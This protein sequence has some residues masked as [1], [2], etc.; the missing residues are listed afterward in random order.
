MLVKFVQTARLREL[1]ESECDE[2]GCPLFSP[3][4]AENQPSATRIAR[5]VVHAM[6]EVNQDVSAAMGHR[7][8]LGTLLP[9]MFIGIGMLDIGFRRK[10]VGP[11]WYTLFWWSLRFF[12]TF[13]GGA[14][15]PPVKPPAPGPG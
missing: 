8:D 7:V 15:R 11:P 5:A 12:M 9:I 3:F 13:N 1:V 4:A 10:P 14:V 2:G 6:G